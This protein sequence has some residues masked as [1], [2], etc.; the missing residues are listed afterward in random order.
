MAD[1]EY[2]LL[3]ELIRVHANV[4][5]PR[6]LAAKKWLTEVWQ[7]QR[8]VRTELECAE[9]RASEAEAKLLL[10]S[11]E[12]RAVRAQFAKYASGNVSFHVNPNAPAGTREQVRPDAD[13]EHPPEL[14]GG[15]EKAV[16]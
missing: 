3:V 16:S 9:A 11:D 5:D 10:L 8:D 14:R 15:D 13:H 6:V 2:K 7:D 12:L 1:R 4:R